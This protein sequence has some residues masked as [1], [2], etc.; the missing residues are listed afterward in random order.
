MVKASELKQIAKNVVTK[1]ES[2]FKEDAQL[3]PL[4]VLSVVNKHLRGL[5]FYESS[6]NRRT[7]LLKLPFYD[8]Y[9]LRTFSQSERRLLYSLGV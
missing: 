6:C 8:K 7:Y 5:N 3:K 2:D 4:F 1:Q 9:R